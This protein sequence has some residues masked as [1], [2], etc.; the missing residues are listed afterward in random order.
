MQTTLLSA[1]HR[2]SVS[3]T[4]SPSGCSQVG[5]PSAH[6]KCRKC[7]VTQP[8]SSC[9]WDSSATRR[10]QLLTLWTGNSRN[11][12]GPR[13]QARRPVGKPSQRSDSKLNTFRV[14][15]PLG[16]KEAVKQG[17][18]AKDC[19]E[20]GGLA[21]SSWAYRRG[22]QGGRAGEGPGQVPTGCRSAQLQVHGE[23]VQSPGP[24]FSGCVHVLMCSAACS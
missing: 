7:A 15:K 14:L 6:T 4:S 21:S 12:T 22:P 18:K 19:W 24:G 11:E 9:R 13:S 16:G 17:A 10:A 8:G 3:Q 20:V 2:G 23:P 1:E 5:A